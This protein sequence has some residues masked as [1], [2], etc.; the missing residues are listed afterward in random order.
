MLGVPRECILRR[1]R[2]RG[3]C[4]NRFYRLENMYVGGMYVCVD[5]SMVGAYTTRPSL[6]I[7]DSI[8]SR[9]PISIRTI[10]A[11]ESACERDNTTHEIVFASCINNCS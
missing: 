5:V 1:V 3:T 7:V 4:I 11:Y 9:A 10:V 8:S 6:Y 2:A